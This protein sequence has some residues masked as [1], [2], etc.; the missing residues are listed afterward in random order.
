MTIVYHGTS[1]SRYSKI[2]KE[3][4]IRPRYNDN[5]NW[6]TKMDGNEN[7]VYLSADKTGAMFHSFRSNIVNN[8]KMGVV[9][10][11]DLDALDESNL[12]VDENY[13][14][15]IERGQ[16]SNCPF[17]VRA[18]QR[19][20]ALDD[21]RW[22]ESLDTVKMMAFYGK[23]DTIFIVNPIFVK[24]KENPWYREHLF[25]S[26][27]KQNMLAFDHHLATHYTETW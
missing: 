5:G 9:L 8:D 24:V 21:K 3:G 10:P 4:F 26:T 15:T 19:E 20:K 22:K 12:R 11:I 27:P 25:I 13:I 6:H 14:D 16:Y 2:L 23:I 18:I 7:L 1:M 17:S